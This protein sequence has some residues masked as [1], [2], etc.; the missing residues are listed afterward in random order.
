MK[1][2]PLAPV[3]DCPRCPCGIAVDRQGRICDGCLDGARCKALNREY[4]TLRL[5]EDLEAAEARVVDVRDLLGWEYRDEPGGW[6]C[7]C[8]APLGRG[9]YPGCKNPTVR[10]I[11]EGE[12]S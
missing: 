8:G 7:V 2:T 9:H 12:G 3:C 1:A 5:R 10:A 11:G 6:F 4:D